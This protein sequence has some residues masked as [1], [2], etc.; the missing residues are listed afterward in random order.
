MHVYRSSFILSTGRVSPLFI[1]LRVI[2]LISIRLSCCPWIWG[3]A[4]VPCTRARILWRPQRSYFSLRPVWVRLVI[5]STTAWYSYYGPTPRSGMGLSPKILM[6]LGFFGV[7]ILCGETL[8]LDGLKNS[9]IVESSP[10]PVFHDDIAI[11]PTTYHRE[12]RSVLGKILIGSLNSAQF[13]VTWITCT[14]MSTNVERLSSV[15]HTM[16]CTQFITPKKWKSIISQ[17]EKNRGIFTSAVDPIASEHAPW[18]R[19]FHF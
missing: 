15:F 7:L 14:Q 4:G 9:S 16:P 8:Y 19:S 13:Q 3:L 18:D 5:G 11:A 1:I 10:R 17:S 2:Q 6:Y 12:Q